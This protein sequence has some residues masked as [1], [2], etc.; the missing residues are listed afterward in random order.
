MLQVGGSQ[1]VV[2]RQA[3]SVFPGSLLEMRTVKPHPGP[4]E[5]EPQGIG[6]GNPCLN[7]TLR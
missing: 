6:P 2:T 3:T 1:S 5:S 4:T 7:K